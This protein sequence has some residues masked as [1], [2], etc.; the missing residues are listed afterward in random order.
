MSL[1]LFLQE[2]LIIVCEP[3]FP[4]IGLN[5][6][7]GLRDQKAAILGFYPRIKVDPLTVTLPDD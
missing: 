2:R 6:I 5:K 7:R 1:P 3:R 4:K